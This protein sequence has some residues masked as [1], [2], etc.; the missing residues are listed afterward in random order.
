MQT[1]VNR[2]AR[3]IALFWA[4]LQPIGLSAQQPVSLGKADAE[5]REPFTQIRTIRELRD[6]RVLVVDPRDRIVQLI[7]FR[8]GT[9]TKVGRT[10]AGPGEYGLPDR[11]I[12]LPGD[13]SAIFDPDNSRYLIITP[14]GSTG[15]TFRIEDGGVRMGGRGAAPRGTDSRGRIFIEGSAFIATA[16]GGIAA[17]DSAPLL[18]VDRATKRLD[19]LAYVQLAKGNA[20]GSG[21]PNGVMMMTGLKAFPS[22]DDWTPLPD[23]GVG[24][25]RVHDY[26]VERYSASGIRTAGPPIT[27]TPIPVTEAEKEAWRAARRGLPA[28]GRGGAIPKNLPPPPQSEFPA[29]MPPFVSAATMARSNGEIWVLRSHRSTDAPV[30]DVFGATGAMV[31]RV[32]MPGPGARLVGFGTNTIYVIRRDADDLE[33]LQRYR[34]P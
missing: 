34:L 12:A 29:V 23:G 28:A 32:A 11:I 27:W 9:A 19:T 25:A 6:G 30:Y 14:E 26:H 7:D 22:R 17:S 8:T 5:F 31:R 4:I 1:S 3:F 16:D 2:R 10:G 24:I 20:R 15:A 21:G 18:R 33:Y 13:S